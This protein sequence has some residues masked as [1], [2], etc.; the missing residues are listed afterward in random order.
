MSL[1]EAPAFIKKGHLPMFWILE[2]DFQNPWQEAY[3]MNL[4]STRNASIQQFASCF[5][6]PSFETFRVI[7]TGW[8]LG[9]GRRTVTHVLLMGGGLKIK[10]F[11][12]YHRFFSQARWTVDSIGRVIVTMA[13]KFI[14]QDAPIVAAID[15]TP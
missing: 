9:S 11:S 4:T 13:L 15:D 6:K 7:V 8:L 1:F 14:P 12:C 3:A 2:K 5:T 10:T